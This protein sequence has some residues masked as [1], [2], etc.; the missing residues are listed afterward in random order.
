[1]QYHPTSERRVYPRETTTGVLS[2]KAYL[3][4]KIEYYKSYFTDYYKDPNYYRNLC[5]NAELMDKSD[6]GIGVKTKLPL[7]VGF[8]MEFADYGTQI[9]MVRWVARQNDYY[10]I[11]L[12]YV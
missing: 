5:G 1:M 3:G 11:G 9:A 2:F 7:E 8:I 6:G 12:M 4:E 10:R